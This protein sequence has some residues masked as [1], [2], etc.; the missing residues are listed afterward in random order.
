MV[1]VGSSSSNVTLDAVRNLDKNFFIIRDLKLLCPQNLLF[2]HF[3]ELIKNINN[4]YTAGLSSWKSD[5]I[6][7]LVRTRRIIIILNREAWCSSF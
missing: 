5:A 6:I 3:N 1:S 7:N 4:L 2:N